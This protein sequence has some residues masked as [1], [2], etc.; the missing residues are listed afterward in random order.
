[1]A[2]WGPFILKFLSLSCILWKWLT[3][4]SDKSDWAQGKEIATCSILYVSLV[5]MKQK[6]EDT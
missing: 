5:L 2:G 3:L 6:D 4:Q 1:M